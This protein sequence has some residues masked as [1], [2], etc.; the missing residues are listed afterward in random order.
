MRLYRKFA[1]FGVL[2]FVIFFTDITWAEPLFNAD[3]INTEQIK[4]IAFSDEWLKL[5]HYKKKIFGGYASEVKGDGFFLSTDGKNDPEAELAKTIE[6]LLHPESDKKNIQ[7]LF[8]ARTKFILK[9]LNL[10]INSVSCPELDAFLKKHNSDSVSYVYSAYYLNSPASIFGHTFIKLNNSSAELLD[11]GVNFNA[12]TENEGF[13]FFEFKGLTGMYPGYYSIVPFYDKV[14]EYNNYENRDLWIYH[15]KIDSDQMDTLV[16]HLWEMM[17][18]HYDYYFLTENCSYYSLSLL[19]PVYAGLELS[20]KTQ[21]FVIPIDTVKILK[22]N[23]LISSIEYRPSLR[24]VF[25]FK[26]NSLTKD[27][28]AVFHSLVENKNSDYIGVKSRILDLLID[29]YDYL[30]PAA[31]LDVLNN[32]EASSVSEVKRKINRARGALDR[33]NEPA[34]VDINHMQISSPDK[35]HEASRISLSVGKRSFS[36]GFFIMPEYRINFHDLSDSTKG[37]PVNSEIEMLKISGYAKVEKNNERKCFLNEINI[38]KITSLNDFGFYQRMPSWS[39]HLGGQRTYDK[40]TVAPEGAFAWNFSLS[41]GLS[42]LVGSGGSTDLYPSLLLFSLANIAFSY[43]AD[44]EKRRY[45]VGV[46]PVIGFKLSFTENLNIMSTAEY[47]RYI[48]SAHSLKFETTLRYLFYDNTAMNLKFV[49]TELY[50]E[51]QSGLMKYF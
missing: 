24:N 2:F 21:Y 13:P 34:D 39:I 37:Y 49:R 28:K 47:T 36:D 18:V 35:M 42:T 45:S 40:R 17:Q 8:P 11:Y 10:K 4:K 9:N 51:I 12:V 20:D 3:N 41:S 48:A 5:C 27:D 25:V 19:D 22:K 7:C 32:P 50:S 31:K 38:L 15:L 1:I 16:R 29:Y 43:S 44:F 26:Y 30:Y 23:N 33:T 14:R 6:L 46:G